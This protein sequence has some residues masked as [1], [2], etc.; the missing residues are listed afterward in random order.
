MT[1]CELLLKSAEDEGEEEE[2]VSCKGCL[3]MKTLAL[4]LHYSQ[5]YHTLESIFSLKQE[6]KLKLKPFLS[7]KGCLALLQAALEFS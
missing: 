7:G 5:F 4:E 1:S 6:E 3:L 2:T